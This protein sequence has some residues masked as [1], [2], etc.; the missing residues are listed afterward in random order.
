[1]E[2]AG[3]IDGELDAHGHAVVRGFL[4]GDRVAALRRCIELLEREG[5]PIT[6]QVLYTHAPPVEPRPPFAHLLRQWF[7]PHRRDGAGNTAAELAHLGL[8]LAALGRPLTPFQDA[9]LIKT[10]AH[11][12]LPWHQDEAYWPFDGA[13]GLVVWIALDAVD[14]RNGGVELAGGSHRFGRGPA[15]DLHTGV[16]QS[17]TAGA[18]PDY[19]AMPRTC[20]TLA[21]GDGLVFHAR[22]WHRSGINESAAPRRGWSSSW[23]PAGIPVR[24]ELA[25]RHPLART[26]QGVT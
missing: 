11:T 3:T 13:G 21:P 22:T 8:R 23:L 20:P 16:R 7:N 25:P 17:G 19:D 10:G 1:M 5:A 18:V 15:I 9:L 26:A 2:A 14:H 4:D 24:P 6:T 12:S